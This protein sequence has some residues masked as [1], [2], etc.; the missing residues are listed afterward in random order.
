MEKF[1][2]SN[3][4]KETFLVSLKSSISDTNSGPFTYSWDN[5]YLKIKILSK[6]LEKYF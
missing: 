4:N 5:I 2:K 3:T 1:H 6:F